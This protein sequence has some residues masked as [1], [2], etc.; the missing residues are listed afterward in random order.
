MHFYSREMR[1]GSLYKNVLMCYYKN[2][3]KVFDTDTVNIG[4]GCKL[5]SFFLCDIFLWLLSS[6]HANLQDQ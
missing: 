2:K 6:P 3:C 5:F 4:T 1:I